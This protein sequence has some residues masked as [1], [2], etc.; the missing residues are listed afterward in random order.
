MKSNYENRTAARE[1]IAG[2]F[3]RNDGVEVQRQHRLSADEFPWSED[4]VETAERIIN[5]AL[6]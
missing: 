1:G 2:V 4:E 5:G 3:A 6:T